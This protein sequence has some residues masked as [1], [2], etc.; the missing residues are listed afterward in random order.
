VKKES[1]EQKLITE[2]YN[3]SL[4]TFLGVPAILL[5]PKA[6]PNMWHIR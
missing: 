4:K 2:G 3:G 6:T 5:V 1:T